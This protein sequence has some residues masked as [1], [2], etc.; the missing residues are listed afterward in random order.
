MGTIWVTQDVIPTSAG[1]CDE[2]PL[3]AC[4]ALSLCRLV[5]IRPSPPYLHHCCRQVPTVPANA[6]K[7]PH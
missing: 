6:A 4:S 1:L 5:G 3:H 2:H 7:A